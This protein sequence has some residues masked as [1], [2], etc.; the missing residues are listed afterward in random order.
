PLEEAQDNMEML[1]EKTL[2]A[3]L[4]STRVVYYLHTKSATWNE[5]RLMCES[6][7]GTLITF[8]DFEAPT[9]AFIMSTRTHGTVTWTRSPIARVLAL[10][11]KWTLTLDCRLPTARKKRPYICQRDDGQCWFQ[12]YVDYKI[13]DSDAGSIL[14]E[15]TTDT[16][17]DCAKTCR[18]DYL[19]SGGGEC[20]A[21]SYDDANKVCLR[22]F[23]STNHK[24]ALNRHAGYFT[25]NPDYTAYVKICTGGWKTSLSPGVSK[26][27]NPWMKTVLLSVSQPPVILEAETLAMTID[28]KVDKI[29][30]ELQVNPQNTSSTR[31]KKESAE[32]SRTSAQGI[33]FVGV[34]F[35]AIVFGG[36]LLLDL[37]VFISGVSDIYKAFRRRGQ[38]DC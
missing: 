1:L 19:A 23:T 20:W 32:D 4:P 5:A 6:Y 35:M 38:S 31:R 37:N 29:V 10:A 30:K 7:G 3:A 15:T 36:I 8:P 34:A 21:F 9:T 28:E 25:T 14:N 13:V 27:G 2:C 24:Y 16:E 11:S 18:R 22:H 17:G 33:G 26:S 12:P